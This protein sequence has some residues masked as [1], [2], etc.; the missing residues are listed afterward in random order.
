MTRILEGYGARRVFGRRS[1]GRGGRIRVGGKLAGPEN[2]T[3]EKL[4][5][6]EC[7]FEPYDDARRQFNIQYYRVAIMFLVFDLEV[8]Y[9]FPWVVSLGERTRL[10]YRTL[11]EF[12]RELIVGFIFVWMVGALEWE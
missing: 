1:G 12:R 10:G 9:R 8:C 2:G 5:A 4:G 6:Y 7:G 11:R 3:E